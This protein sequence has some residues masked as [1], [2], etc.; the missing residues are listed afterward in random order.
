M[1]P[2]LKEQYLDKTYQYLLVLL[3]FLIPLTV[4]GANLIIV[5]ICLIWLF[6]GEYHNK[7]KRIFSSKILISS[8]IFFS[9][10]LIGLIWTQDIMWGLEIIHKMWYFLL[11]FPILFTIVKRKYI[12]TYI[13]S[14]LLAIALTEIFSF[15]I[16]F[17]VIQPFKNAT[18]SNPTPFMSHISYNPI[19]AFSTY[20]VLHQIFLNKNLEGFMFFGHVV[21]AISMIVNMFITSGRAGQVMFFAML[22]ILIFQFFN[23]E[24]IKS[25]FAVLIIIPSIF[26]LAYQTNDSFKNRVNIT[27]ENSTNYSKLNDDCSIGCAKTS[28]V[29]QRIT[30]A[31]HSW[32]IIKRHPILGVGT[33][34]FPSEFKKIN[35][36]TPNNPNATN[37]HN[38]YLLVMTQLGIIGLISFLSIFYFMIKFSFSSK[39]QF[40]R[41]TGLTLP[42]LFLLVMFSDSY[43]LGHYTT[44]MFVFFSSF[45][46][47]NFEKP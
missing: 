29:G 30:F 8:I 44:L 3:A 40:I 42:L 31:L 12:K 27:I 10:H 1:F 35:I 7:L 24:K 46:Y 6:S 26:F 33:G 43:L 2:E 5:I 4:F 20:I 21:F 14:F 37:P 11:L 17:E 28:S 23:K 15:L 36:K 19:L 34:D 38:M 41:D 16:W 39:N 9:I 13:Y 18:I 32:E 22:A 25:L 47:N 45:L